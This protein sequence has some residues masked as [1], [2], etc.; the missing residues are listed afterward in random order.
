MKN[1]LKISI[2]LTLTIIVV[3]GFALPLNPAGN[4]YQQFFPNLGGRNIL[5]MTFLDSLTGYTITNISSDTSYILKTT[6]GG[7]NWVI[8]HRA[9]SSLFRNIQFLNSNTGYVS[10]QHL[11]KTTNAGNNWFLVYFSLFAEDSYFINN[12]TAWYED[13]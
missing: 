8:N 4:W 13:P 9:S 2:A 7:D 1:L 12:D 10:G 11:I 3:F 6:N 5:D